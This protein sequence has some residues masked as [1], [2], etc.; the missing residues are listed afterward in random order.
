[1]AIEN[2]DNL[3]PQ[4]LW[5][6]F[7]EITDVPRPSKHEQRIIAYLVEFA[8]CR[9]LPCHVDETG[10]VLIA[11]GGSQ[12]REA[13]QT[14]ALQAHIDMVAEKDSDLEFDF[15]TQPISA[16]I[17]DGW[18]KARG[19]TLGADCG[20]GM[21]VMLALLDSSDISH[22]PI[23][24]LFTTD[25]ET[26]LTGAFALAKDLLKAKYLINVDSE[27]SGEIFVG[28]AGGVDSIATFSYKEEA[29]KEGSISLKLSV[30][31]LKGGHSGDD[32]DKRRGNANILLSR[33]LYELTLR[34]IQWQLSRIDGGNLR[35][36]IPR[37]AEATI[38]IMAKDREVVEA[39]ITRLDGEFKAEH[40]VSEPTLA[41]KIEDSEQA[42]V[43]IDSIVVQNLIKSVIS[44]INGVTAMSQQIEGFVESST[45][46]ASIKQADNRIVIS[47]SQRSSLES[48]K[49]LMA[50]QMNLHFSSYGAK[51]IHSDG[52]PGWNPQMDSH[53]LEVAVK[54]HNSALGY[55]P[56]VR[57]IHAGLE[58]GLIKEKYPDMEM[59]SIGPTIRDAHSPSERLSVKDT[60]EFWEYLK[61]ILT[62][63]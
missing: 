54:C 4:S 9:N 50:M 59:I 15:L 58:C 35:N 6:F 45:N 46:L 11:K 37:E 29:I 18:V 12:G 43:A 23:E 8:K 22:P 57:A 62:Q 33:A 25:E 27:D 38:S 19:T 31:G 49:S 41:L 61:E 2:I 42:D 3:K 26:G 44:A 7:S 55:Q 32:I 63:I 1:M 28:C 39:I 13:A 56:K 14:V 47:T 30:S 34:G 52:Y 60:Q 36:A 40:E 5:G 17:E 51:M 53:L 21:A 48:K 20:I 10:N 16:Y 24:A